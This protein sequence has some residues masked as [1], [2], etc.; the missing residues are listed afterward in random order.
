M[1]AQVKELITYEGKNVG[2]KTEP[3]ADYLANQD[4]IEFSTWS[5][6][7]LRGYIG[8]WEIR[9]KKLFIIDLWFSEDRERDREKK[10]G[11]SYCFTDK[12]KVFAEWFSGDIIIPQGKIIKWINIGYQS[13]FEKD[14]ILNFKNG[15]LIS[16]RIKDNTSL[17]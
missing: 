1:T 14:L 11:L 12:S 9:N 6:A 13:I 8:T 17:K 10:L 2:M 16:K 3:L 4:K 5:T 7:C 15:V